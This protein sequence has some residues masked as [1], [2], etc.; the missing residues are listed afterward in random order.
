MDVALSIAIVSSFG[1]TQA[2]YRV[3]EIHTAAQIVMIVLAHAYTI[4]AR[5]IPFQR[6]RGTQSIE[7]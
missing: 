6:A 1:C 5:P 2:G 3:G 4:N 7:T